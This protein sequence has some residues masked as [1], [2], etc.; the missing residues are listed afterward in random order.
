MPPKWSVVYHPGVERALELHL[1][2]TFKHD[3]KVY[4]IHISPDGQRFAVGLSGNGKTYI[5]ELE[6][7]SNI[8]LDSDPLV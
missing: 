4:C 5:N 3:S 6:T 1:A 2:H 7:G 8:R